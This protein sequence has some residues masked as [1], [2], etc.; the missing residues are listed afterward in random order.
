VVVVV[1]PANVFGGRSRQAASPWPALVP[2]TVPEE[3]IRGLLRQSKKI[4]A[5]K[6]YHEATGVGLKEAKDAVEAMERGQAVAAIPTVVT[7]AA[8]QGA[9]V[10]LL[11]QGKKIQ[12][13]KLYRDAT[14]AGLADAKEAVEALERSN[15]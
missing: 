5:I 4:Q 1:I 14:G 7:D 8:S 2:G 11:R 3:Q 10:D 9:I 13:I 15:R 12:A 6:L